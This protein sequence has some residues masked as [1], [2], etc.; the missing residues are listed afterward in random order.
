MAQVQMRIQQ[1]YTN[2]KEGPNAH[3]LHANDPIIV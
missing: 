1:K 3:K 2:K